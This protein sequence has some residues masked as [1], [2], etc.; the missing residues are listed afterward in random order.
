MSLSLI[1]YIPHYCADSYWSLDSPT[2]L[3]GGT[4]DHQIILI[5]FL[6]AADKGIY[7]IYYLRHF[8]VTKL[9]FC[10]ITPFGYSVFSIDP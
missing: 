3:L 5:L 2:T 7:D 6:W 8:V 4:P 9:S 10:Y 1:F